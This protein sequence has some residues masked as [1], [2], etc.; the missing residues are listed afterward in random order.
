MALKAVLL[1]EL[2]KH[3]FQYR[4][5]EAEWFTLASGERSPEYLDCK[6]A[7][8]RSRAMAV[9]GPLIH[10]R[11]ERSVVALGGLTMGADPIAMSTC[12]ASDGTTHEVRWFVV[13]KDRKAHGQK[14]LI[15]GAVEPG[16]KVAVV[17]DVVTSGKSTIQ[18]IQACRDFGLDVV[19]VIVLVDREQLDGL[20]NIKRAAGGVP[21]EAI[22]RKSQIK[23]EW[24]RLQKQPETSPKRASRPFAHASARS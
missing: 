12:Q 19:Q 18:A 23:E 17:D 22:F 24:Q 3:A 9:L 15:E 8:S 11:L 4:A 21:V 2:A 6:H 5:D 16:D 1:S 13:R 10:K 14:K 20:Q 7:L